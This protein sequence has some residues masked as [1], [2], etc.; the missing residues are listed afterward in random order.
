M[1]RSPTIN[2]NARYDDNSADINKHGE[3]TVNSNARYDDNSADINRT[4]RD[5]R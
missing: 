5:H 1:E 3:I 4:R 2:S